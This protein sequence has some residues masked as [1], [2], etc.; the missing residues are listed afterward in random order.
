MNKRRLGSPIL[1]AFLYSAIFCIGISCQ[2]KG[3]TETFPP[4]DM[5]KS[6]RYTVTVDGTPVL[7]YKAA[8]N[9]NVAT[10]TLSKPVEV[11]V[12][13][14]DAGYWN[15]G[16]NIRPLSKGIVS[17]VE[18]QTVSFQLD[19]PAMLSVE[20]ANQI[21]DHVAELDLKRDDPTWWKRGYKYNETLQLCSY[22]TGATEVLFIFA[23]TPQTEPYMKNNTEMIRLKPGI[24]AGNIDLKS[25][26]HLHLD[27]GAFLFGSV[28]IWNAENVKVTGKGV[29]IHDGD[30]PPYTDKGF[31]T[32]RNWR[33]ISINNSQ[34]VSVSGVTCIARSRTWTIQATN[35]RN[36]EFSSLRI[37]G[38][39]LVNLNGDGIDLCG[40]QDVVIKDCFFRT[41]DDAIA[42]YRNLPFEDNVHHTWGGTDY[43]QI[44]NTEVRN[45]SI[46][47]CVF[48][49]TSANVMRVGWTGM[50]LKTSNITMTDC[51]VIH[52][53]DCSYFYAP[54]SLLNIMSQD[55]SG[56]AEHSD[57]LFE[58]IRLEEY[59]ALVGIR[60]QN[61]KFRNIHFKNIQMVEASKWP[62]L[63]IA[64]HIDKEKGVI[65]EDISVLGKP[66]KEAKDLPMHTEEGYNI[67]FRP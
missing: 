57:Y 32:E 8:M 1:K 4:A 9:I 13:V 29:I 12:E 46:S 15:E 54:H 17:Q 66:V 5:M 28:N 6:D 56:E 7:V 40:A 47:N 27:E 16:V 55:G 35:S 37:I 64:P 60:H 41:C 34:D 48:W 63:I 14:K 30:Q 42:L 59:S 11:K 20:R 50:P 53:S 23:D 65:F 44:V 61:A 3:G 18:G 58:N 31:Q 21:W 26:Q 2:Q 51:D 38:A 19:G 39:N 45:V 25:G 10:I 36:L 22:A 62:S 33:P 52:L 49:N 67:E 43:S 24:H